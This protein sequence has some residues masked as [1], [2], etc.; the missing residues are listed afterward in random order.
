[1]FHA[2]SSARRSFLSA[3]RIVDA[4]LHLTASQAFFRGNA[5]PFY[6]AK[7]RAL[8]DACGISA[9]L[10]SANTAS[11]VAARGANFLREALI[12]RHETQ[13]CWYGVLAVLCAVAAI[14]A[15]PASAATVTYTNVQN[16]S[17]WRTCGACGNT[18]GT[19]L[20]AKYTMTQHVSSPSM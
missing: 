1:M 6:W 3:R 9:P 8:P 5:A 13:S 4:A 18:G 7:A 16:S 20:V 10:L 19:G 15:L 2:R 14:A 17:G 11:P 12:L